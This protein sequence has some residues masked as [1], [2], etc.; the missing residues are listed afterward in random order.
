MEHVHKDSSG[1]LFDHIVK[2]N[3]LKNDAALARFINQTPAVV[4]KV[5]HGRLSV[6]PKII[7]DIHLATGM[8]V[9]DIMAL[10]AE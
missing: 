3:S 2:A 4:S 6:S 7:L 5:R 1:K 9:R 8:A 10:L